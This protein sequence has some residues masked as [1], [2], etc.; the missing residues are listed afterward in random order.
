MG[1][2]RH[3]EWTVATD[4]DA[5]WIFV[6]DNLDTHRSENLVR[7]VATTCEESGDVGKKGHDGP[8][9][10]RDSRAAD[11]S[12]PTYRIRCVYTPKHCSWLNE[13]ERWFS[14]LARPSTARMTWPRRSTPTSTTTTRSVRVP[15]GGGRNLTT[16]S[17]GWGLRLEAH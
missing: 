6:V 15:I 2:V 8:L 10:N 1:F 3:V 9:R 14:K 17:G 13:V 11:L 5:Q 4:P 12:D 7:W 16:C